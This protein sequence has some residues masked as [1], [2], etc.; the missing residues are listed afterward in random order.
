MQL[1]DIHSH[2]LKSTFDEIK[3]Y[4]HDYQKNTYNTDLKT[5][6]GIHPWSIQALDINA[7]L[8][9]LK[10][11][12]LKKN[13]FALGEI[14]L[15]R[16][17]AT[18]LSEQIKVF[19]AQ[20]EIAN[21]LNISRLVIHN[22]RASFDIIPILKEA[23]IKAKI[24]LHDFNEN[25]QVFDAFNNK[26]DTYF[27]CGHQLFKNTTIKKELGNLPLAKLLLETDDQDQ[28]NIKEIYLRCSEILGINEKKL[29]EKLFENYQSFIH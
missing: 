4:I 21:E 3:I 11:D 1:I 2:H 19:K 27:S 23:N 10:T 9:Q 5:C 17:I 13:T 16:S 6:Y 14:G 15:D 28:Y 18:P 24:L 12:L 25:R 26:F 7:T 29:V 8:A 22:V 20:L